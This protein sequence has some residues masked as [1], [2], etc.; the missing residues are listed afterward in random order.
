MKKPAPE[1]YLVGVLDVVGLSNALQASNEALQENVDFL[2]WA[3]ST[4]AEVF[5]QYPVEKNKLAPYDEKLLRIE[6]LLGD[7]ELK[8]QTFADL[9]VPF[10]PLHR[11]DD[12]LRALSAILQCSTRPARCSWPRWPAVARSAAASIRNAVERAPIRF[13]GAH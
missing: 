2:Q 12:H 6:N 1:Q 9:I 10:T 8:I 13:M 3:A 5:K 7:A 4:C 11:D